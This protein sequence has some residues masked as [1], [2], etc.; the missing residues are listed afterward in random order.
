MSD[1]ERH[2]TWSPDDVETVKDGDYVLYAD[3]FAEVERLQAEL[4]ASRNAL[5]KVQIDASRY[6]FL[7]DKTKAFCVV[8]AFTPLYSFELD[9]AIDAEIGDKS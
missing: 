4:S 1:I 3:H 8:H 6:Q 5:T 2:D 7:R 9:E